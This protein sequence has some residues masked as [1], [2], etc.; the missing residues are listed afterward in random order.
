[1]RTLSILLFLLATFQTSAQIQLL[2]ALRQEQLSQQQ[3]GYDPDALTFIEA[4]EFTARTAKIGQ[5]VT[6]LPNE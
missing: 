3:S 5:G 1:M 6:E 4:V 2:E